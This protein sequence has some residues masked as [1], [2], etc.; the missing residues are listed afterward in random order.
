MSDEQNPQ[1]GVVVIDNFSPW[2]DAARASA[3]AAGFGTWRPNR[4]EV[5]SSIY[6][7]MC[8]WGDHAMML[9]PLIHHMGA[10]IVPNSMFFRVCNEATEGAYVHSDREHGDFTAVVYLSDHDEP[11]FGTGF[12]RNKRTGAD[13]MAPMHVMAERDPTEFETLK[14]EM[15][16][17]SSDAWDCTSF[18]RGSF[19]RAV[20]FEAP[21]YHA[22][23]PRHGLGDT[24]ENG[25]MV[26]VCH[27]MILRGAFNG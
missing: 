10:Q 17:G 13:R 8:F 9:N 24:A 11:E 25:R 16:E 5:G 15:V 22:R 12:Y 6:D 27:F 2:A 23:S 21:L 3:L 1:P 20:I 19:N 18:V 4:G 7:G 14:A 26:W